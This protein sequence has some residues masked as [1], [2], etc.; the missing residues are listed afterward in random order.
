[1]ENPPKT[2]LIVPDGNRR[3][4]KQPSNRA[5]RWVLRTFFGFKERLY[6]RGR[7]KAEEI[8]ESAFQEGVTWIYFLGATW[9]NL[10]KRPEIAQELAQ[11]V[12]ETLTSWKERGYHKGTRME[13]VGSWRVHL[14]DPELAEIIRETEEATAHY[15]ERYLVILFGHEGDRERNEYAHLP[16]IELMIRTGVRNDLRLPGLTLPLKMRNM[17][18]WPHGR[19]FWPDFTPRDLK[20]ALKWWSKVPKNNGK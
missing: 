17:A 10:E 3:W 19:M 4:A 5:K 2:I 20:R 1:M 8:I 9:E 11:L 16:D 13:I 14:C 12:K 18:I 7:N 6:D 15:C